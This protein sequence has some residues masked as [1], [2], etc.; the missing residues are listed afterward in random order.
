MFKFMLKGIFRDRHRY[1][2]P[3]II[4]SSGI[5]I[6]VFMLAFM[7]GYTTSFISHNSRFDTGHLKV[8]TRAYARQINFKPIDLGMLDI[9]DQV[10]TWKQAYPQ[11]D[12]VQRISF[13]ALL[14]VP[15]SLGET[16]EQGEVVGFAIDLFHNPQERA[17]LNL[18]KALVSGRLPAAQGEVLLSKTAFERLD[19]KLGDPV[20]LIGSTV[21]GAMAMYNL[22]VVGAVDFGVYSLDRGAVIADISDIRAM[23]DMEGGAGEV[24]A[25]FKH[26]RYRHGEVKALKEDFNSRFSG[27][28]EF[29]VEML[30]LTDQGNLGYFLSIMKSSLGI[31]SF[32][33]ILILGIVLWN[34][35][36][37]NGIRRWGEFGLRLAV[38]ERKSQVYFSLVIEAIVLGIAGS[39]LGI[40]VGGAI[41][42]YF[43][44]HP[45]DVSAYA[46]SSSIVSDSMI[47]TSFSLKGLLTGLLTGV[48][49]T[50]IGA[51]LA[52]IPIFRRQTSQLFKELET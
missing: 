10:E 40:L 6:L 44:Y 25:Y 45:I 47:S 49:S 36:L 39:I 22:N 31:V 51:A 30:A 42:L 23:L 15:D 2:F 19:L 17:R 32:V 41:S 13:G 24:L 20:T 35:G 29:D 28:D 16:R 50:F 8:V 43:N 4:V 12:W 9:Q 27:P 5:A 37:M 7:D 3:L 48:M 26:G 46:R 11:M 18:D 33:F 21:H 38:G 34:S 14:D 52:G 1:L